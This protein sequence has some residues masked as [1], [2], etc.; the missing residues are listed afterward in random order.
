MAKNMRHGSETQ[1]PQVEVAEVPWLPAERLNCHGFYGTWV[2]CDGPMPR[3][4]N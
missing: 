2:R 3:M 4:H 1:R